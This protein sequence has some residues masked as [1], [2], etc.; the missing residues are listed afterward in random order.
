LNTRLFF[1]K[2]TSLQ[3]R[4]NLKIFL[5]YIAKKEKTRIKDLNIIFCSDEFLLDI[6]RSFLNHDY[7][8]DIITFEISKDKNGKI[9]EL[10]ISVDSV[11]KNSIDYQ[12]TKRNE[13]HRVIFH[14]VLHL[15]GYKDKSK[16]DISLMRS[17]ED[18]YLKLYFNQIA[19][20][21]VEH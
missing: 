7:N 14:G 10:Y 12:S 9:A 17:K 16:N 11:S 6:N 2:K 15:C 3:N 13:L 8:T 5:N 1:Q 18:E 20:F 21:H 4:S 19:M